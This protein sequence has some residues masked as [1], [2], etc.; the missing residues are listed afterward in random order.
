MEKIIEFEEGRSYNC[1]ASAFSPILYNKLFPGRDFIKDMDVLSKHAGEKEGEGTFGVE[2]YS[3]FA[4]ITYM[5]VYQGM[6]PSPK[7][8][9]EQKE[10]LEKYPTPWD[11][12]DTFDTFSIYK[13]LDAIVE[14]WGTNEKRISK[15]KNRVSAPPVK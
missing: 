13:N 8:T 1:K 12:I 3:Y 14:L 15:L 2:E 5:F 7:Q 10:F 11:W 4:N 6:A 9:E